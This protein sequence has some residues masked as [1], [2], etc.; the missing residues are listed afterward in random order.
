MTNNSAPTIHVY[1]GPD[2][3][4]AAFVDQHLREGDALLTYRSG[5]T[6]RAGDERGKLIPDGWVLSYNGGDEHIVWSLG[7]RRH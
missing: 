5:S 3:E 6:T 7:H 2:Q 4:I 1:Y